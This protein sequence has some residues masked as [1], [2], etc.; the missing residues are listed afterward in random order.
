MTKISRI[1][2][3]ASCLGV[4]GIAAL[5]VSGYATTSSATADVEVQIDEECALGSGVGPQD[6]VITFGSG[7]DSEDKNATTNMSVVCNNTWTLLEKA[8]SEVNL[9]N[10]A[11]VGFTPWTGSTTNASG[12]GGNNWSM[13][14]VGTDVATPATLY[15]A[16]STSDF[17]VVNSASSTGGS[18]ITQVLGAKTDGTVPAGTYTTELTY[19]LNGV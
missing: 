7:A 14:Y 8:S 3:A 18:V 9:K 12:F 11:V 6:I 13:K 4:M 16:V 5:P 2:A 1:L 10:G 19:T 15:H 17:T